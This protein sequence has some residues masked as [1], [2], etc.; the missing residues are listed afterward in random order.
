MGFSSAAAQGALE[1]C[2]WDVNAALDKLFNGPSKDNSSIQ[3]A[4][5]Q[6]SP[7]RMG[8]RT[9]VVSQTFAGNDKVKAQPAKPRGT[10]ACSTSASGGSTPRRHSQVSP[11]DS[12][13]QD[14]SSGDDFI[15]PSQRNPV[16]PPGLEEEMPIQPTLLALPPGLELA[17]DERPACVGT[18]K[19]TTMPESTSPLC[20]Q[21]PAGVVPI[22]ATPET[23]P[24]SVVPKRRL[25]KVQHTW[26]CEQSSQQMS[27]EENTFVYVWNGSKT[28]TGW[29]YAE[30][31][32]C[33][34]R[35]GWLPE[36]MLQQLPPGRQWMRITKSCAATFPMQLQVEVGNMVL[37]DASQDPVNGWVY[38]EQVGSATGRPSLQDLLGSGG[39][40]PIQCVER[41]DV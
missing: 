3:A 5:S 20:A 33:G 19:A 26:D 36:S 27:V 35:A 24:V 37:V 31:V 13:Q 23:G 38:A 29:I 40:V 10:D 25:M 34:S 9:E 6:P 7:K 32:I 8:G 41:A 22:L 14:T 15:L 2:G 30:S 18:A 28:E 16:L 1:E 12:P 17:S 39:W 21:L 4:D 11:A